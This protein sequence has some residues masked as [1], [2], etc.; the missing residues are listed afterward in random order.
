MAEMFGA[1]IRQNCQHQTGRVVEADTGT[2]VRT[3]CHAV[4]PVDGDRSK[5]EAGM[6]VSRKTEG[7]YEGIMAT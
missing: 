1:E 2:S 5:A 6:T 7:R 4:A 3:R